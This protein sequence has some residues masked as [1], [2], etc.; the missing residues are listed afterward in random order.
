MLIEA[1]RGG[2]TAVVNLLLEYPISISQENLQ[3]TINEQQILET[4]VGRARWLNQEGG[5]ILLKCSGLYRY[6]T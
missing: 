5:F 1:A 3:L 2:H 4:E 6:N